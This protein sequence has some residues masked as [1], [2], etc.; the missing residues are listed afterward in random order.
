MENKKGAIKKERRFVNSSLNEDNFEGWLTP[1][2]TEN[3]VFCNLLIYDKIKRVE[4]K[5]AAFFSEH[6]IA[7]YTADHLIPLLKKYFTNIVKNVIARRETE[8]IID[9]LQTRGCSILID[10]STDISNLKIM[11]VLV[12]FL[13]LDSKIFFSCL[14][15]EVPVV[16]M[17]NCIYHSS[18]IMTSK[19]CEKLPQS[20]ENLIRGIATY[21]SGSTKKCAI[22]IEFQEIFDNWEVLKNYFIL[23][24]IEDKLKSAEIILS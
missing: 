13:S 10:E 7:F 2:P 8:K 4:I 5:L 15:S 9:I 6:N 20:C 19:A 18:A 22:L 14:Q 24:V 12:Q 23:A 21:I 11:C 16:V 3:K 17:L 1:Y